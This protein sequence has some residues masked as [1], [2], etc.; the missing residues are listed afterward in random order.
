[1]WPVLII[2]VFVLFPGNRV[3][4]GS[5]GIVKKAKADT[6]KNIYALHFPDS[7]SGW[8]V[9]EK[10]LIMHTSDGGVTWSEQKSGIEKSN[11]LSV[12]F[13][14]S[15]TGWACGDIYDGPKVRRGHI[16]GGRPMTCGAI[17]KT[18]DG[19]KTWKQYWGP[20]NFKL[21]DIWMI[22]RDRGVIVNHGGNRHKDGDTIRGSGGGTK[23]PRTKRAFRALN[24]VQF[25][26]DTTGI[27]VGTRVSVGF[28]PPPKDP[29]Y[30][31]KTCRVIRS[32]DGGKSWKPAEHPSM[33][34][35]DE[36]YSV[37]FSSGK[38]GWACGSHGTVIYSFDSG[39]TWKKQES[40]V[41]ADLRD[42]HA[43]DTEKG[44]AVGDKGVIIRTDDSGTSWRTVESGTDVTLRAVWFTSG[45]RGIIAG[46]KGTILIYEEVNLPI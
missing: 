35:A 13:L 30:I 40:N 11:L 39:K 42:I 31:Q 26:N 2:L 37:H 18:E 17:L 43:A 16:V 45:T 15:K 36:L 6:D 33:K 9:G 14:D 8:A 22:D 23:W 21:T 28:F 7:S 20:G 41:K 34:G 4:A 24:A 38:T 1:M 27:A 3:Y 25:L 5:D 19:G 12:F 46:D 10:G 32:E 29:L 44:W